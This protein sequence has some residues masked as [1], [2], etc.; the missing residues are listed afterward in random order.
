MAQ[1]FDFRL[2]LPDPTQQFQT[3][4]DTTSK[5][6]QNLEATKLA[7]A[8]AKEQE[9]IN[10]ARQQLNDKLNAFSKIQNPTVKDY[11]DLALYLPKDQAESVRKNW[12]LLSE[13]RQKNEL[14]FTGRVMAAF[15]S[16][17][18][19]GI[20]LLKERAEAEKNA[21]NLKEAKAY[22]SWAK[23]A[24]TNPEAAKKAIGTM[25][26]LVPGGGDVIES[27]GKLGE[28]ERASELQQSKI[29]KAAA[30]LGYTKAQTKEKLATVKKLGVE[31]K[32]AILELDKM[33]EQGD[34]IPVEK[35]FNME[36]T[37]R[38]D[39][40]KR[41]AGV[42]ESRRNLNIISKSAAAKSGV[43]DVALITAFLKMLDPGSV[44]RETE[45]AT[46][47]NTAGLITQMQNWLTQRAKG[48]LL[49]DDQRQEY[50]NLANEYMKA[51]EIQEQKVKKD[52]G[53]TIKSYELN[54]KNVF[55]AEEVEEKT[56]PAGEGT[57]LIDDKDVTADQKAKVNI[58]P[59]K[60]KNKSYAK[61]LTNG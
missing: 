15:D 44:V 19:I 22:E 29:D 49:Q 58:V 7:Q 41:T 48:D 8:K 54:P 27:L 10:L 16:S 28:E 9:Q 31:T 39:Y 11:T 51:A 20:N 3:G 6:L 21:G 38:N 52:L 2:N 47:R 56:E 26:S 43:G 36:N 45:F 4:F 25:V 42:V 59:E 32:K 53:E 61:W 33:K 46:A 60:F 55:G 5:I 14:K 37:L 57:V 35:K 30:D 24:E 40:N 23:I 12:D 17:P 1:Q 34:D 13:D 50:I 18:E